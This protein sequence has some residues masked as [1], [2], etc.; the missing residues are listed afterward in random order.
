MSL[1]LVK[2]S[3]SFGNNL[4]IPELSLEILDGEFITLLGPSGCGKTTLLRMIA[5]FE[6]PSSGSVVLDGEDITPLPPYRRNVN[7]VFQNYALF[8]HLNVFENVAYGL[9]QKGIR[10]EEL[11]K[12]VMAVLEKVQMVDFINR[13]PRELSGGQ[14]QRVALARAIV[15]KP[16]VLLLDEPL[17]AL[18]LKLRKQMQIELKQLHRE[19]GMTFVFVTHDQEEALTM[20]DRIAVMNKGVIEQLADPQTLYER[21]RTKFV[22]DF[23]GENNT[24]I[25]EVHNG[26]FKGKG[27]ELPVQTEVRGKAMLFIRPE[28]IFFNIRSQE[29]IKVRIVDKTFLGNMWRIRCETLGQ[30]CIDV[31][32]KPDEVEKLSDLSEAYIV[33]RQDK[34]NIINYSL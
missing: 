8:P 4:V 33:W 23:I 30:E 14:Q 17:S 18:D 31:T 21:P 2:I 19:L 29:G 6:L 1:Q 5:G 15:N 34:A 10:G 32:I 20:S 9:R 12:Q 24:L 28:H 16:K 26:V 7:T 13:K 27:F 25:G 3:K 22:A 11:K